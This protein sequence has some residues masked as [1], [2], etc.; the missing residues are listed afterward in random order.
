M[1]DFRKHLTRETREVLQEGP[2][3]AWQKHCRTGEVTRVELSYEILRQERKDTWI[4]F[5]LYGG[6]TGY[7]SFVIDDGVRE[8]RHGPEYPHEYWSAC[9]GTE[10]VYHQLRIHKNEMTRVLSEYFKGE[11]NEG[12]T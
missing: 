12:T 1:V 9:A 5:Q 7:E 6:P 11:P 2:I 4:V 8:R 10:G 3:I